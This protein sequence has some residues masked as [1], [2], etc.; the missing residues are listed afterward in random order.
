MVS[1]YSQMMFVAALKSKY[2]FVNVG[3][4]NLLSHLQTIRMAGM[5]NRKM[6]SVFLGARMS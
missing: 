4:D 2:F 5:E 1:E 3:E 6:R